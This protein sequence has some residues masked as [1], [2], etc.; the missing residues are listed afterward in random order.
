MSRYLK[1]QFKVHCQMARDLKLQFK[2]PC[3]MA[4]Y[5]KLQFKVTCHLARYLKLQFNVPR[6]I[7]RLLKLQ[8]KVH[9]QMARFTIKELSQKIKFTKALHA[10]YGLCSA[11]IFRPCV[12]LL[13]NHM[14]ISQGLYGLI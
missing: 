6:Q 13:H 8:F 10:M 3:Q 1:M 9:C 11:I 5:L 14:H 2:V 12:P 7:A 4:R